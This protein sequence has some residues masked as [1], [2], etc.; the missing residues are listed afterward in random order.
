MIL[1]SHTHRPSSV[2]ILS[3]MAE[4][5]R[6]SLAHLLCSWGASGQSRW[7]GAVAAI[8]TLAPSPSGDSG[9]FLALLRWGQ[10]AHLWR[11]GGGGCGDSQGHTSWPH[12]T[13]QVMGES[14]CWSNPSHP[15]G[16]QEGSPGVPSAIVCDAARS[17]VLRNRA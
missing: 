15:R 2:L 11:S 9:S 16:D 6:G 7:G 3:P 17:A 13:S 14:R 5:P 1:K 10:R 12:P 4:D 8:R